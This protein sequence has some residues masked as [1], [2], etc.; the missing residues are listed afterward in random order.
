MNIDHYLN[1]LRL[2]CDSAIRR[3]LR[4]GYARLPIDGVG[5]LAGVR[6]MW[7]FVRHEKIH[8]RGNAF[9]INTM[10]PPITADT[11]RRLLPDAAVCRWPAP[12]SVNV[13][14]TGRCPY[15][16]A[17]CSFGAV[18]NRDLSPSEA[19][20]RL[21]QID[22]LRACIVGFTGGEP[23]LWPYLCDAVG[24]ASQASTTYLFTSGYWLD[25]GTA[26]RLY[27]AGL[28]A[29]FV[30]LD[31]FDAVVVNRLRPGPDAYGTAARA[32]GAARAA[33]LYV[34]ANATVLRPLVEG[35]NLWR[36][37]HF[38]RQLGAHA[39]RLMPPHPV[40][41]AADN[42]GLR[43]NAR[44]LAKIAKFHIAAN[45]VRG[46]PAVTA[47]PYLES[48]KHFGCLGGFHHA[49]VNLS[50][51][52]FP[53]DFAPLSFG[54]V[55]LEPLRV[56]WRRMTESL[57]QPGRTCITRACP[58]VGGADA[59]RPVAVESVLSWCASRKVELPDFFLEFPNAGA[60]I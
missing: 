29:V 28:F 48:P 30:S 34:V 49:Y 60:A 7:R 16:C 23:L 36:Y 35:D 31:H 58:H 21:R 6:W 20:E 40:G 43:L 50:G 24:R 9:I 52:V 37:V 59:S 32:I 25:A 10:Y 1:G 3:A 13:A 51:Q 38:A 39:V 33:G 14:V 46:L 56:I 8:R 53:C 17:H 41:R 2:L 47:F 45:R 57:R 27:A 12:V 44:E 19:A 11:L 22:A 55:R 26:R 18:V 15:R 5:S 42:R 54:N 4:R